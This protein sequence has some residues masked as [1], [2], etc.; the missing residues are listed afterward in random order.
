MQKELIEL[1]I[2]S[3]NALN[4]NGYTPTV[5]N[6]DTLLRK[7]YDQFG[8]SYEKMTDDEYVDFLVIL[9]KWKPKKIRLVVDNTSDRDPRLASD[10]I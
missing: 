4:R 1:V 9:S 6:V 7:L 10:H 8:K 2:L 5:H 3:I